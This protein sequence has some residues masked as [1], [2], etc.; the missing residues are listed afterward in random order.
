METNPELYRET[1][2]DALTKRIHDY[3]IGMNEVD[4]EVKKLIRGEIT[5]VNQIKAIKEIGTKG[6]ESKWAS[7]MRQAK[8][9]LEKVKK[10]VTE[11]VKSDL[12]TIQGQ[13]KSLKEKSGG[14]NSYLTSFYQKDK[15]NIEKMERDLSSYSNKN[16]TSSP[17]KTP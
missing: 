12:K 6:A 1:I 4:D 5:D 13:F 16:Q 17:A 7:L 9:L 10:G 11:Q 8:E 3:G 15:D 14:A 2:I